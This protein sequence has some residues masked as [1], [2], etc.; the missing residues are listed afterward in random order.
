MTSS[1][2]L[3]AN[4]NPC[5]ESY[6][7]HSHASKECQRLRA[8]SFASESYLE[9]T[10]LPQTVSLERLSKK[11]GPFDHHFFEAFEKYLLEAIEDIKCR[12]DSATSM[13]DDFSDRARRS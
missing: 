11:N 10:Q 5:D 9:T 12:Q 4:N 2:G 6:K 8:Q 1:S 13:T 7:P 3:A